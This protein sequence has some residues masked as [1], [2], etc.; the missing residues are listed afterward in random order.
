LQDIKSEATSEALVEIEKADA[1]ALLLKFNLSTIS[2]S[3]LLSNLNFDD[4]VDKL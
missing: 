2:Y 4:D 3:G 1:D